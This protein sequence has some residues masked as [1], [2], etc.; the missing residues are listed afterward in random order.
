MSREASAC[1]QASPSPCAETTHVTAAHMSSWQMATLQSRA[2]RR[3]KVMPCGRKERR[4]RVHAYVEKSRSSAWQE[5]RH[6]ARR[7]V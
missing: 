7:S 5:G 2:E 3:C 1:S 4:V 6:T